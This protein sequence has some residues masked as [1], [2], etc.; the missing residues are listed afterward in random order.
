MGDKIQLARP[1]EPVEPWP[2]ALAFLV[3]FMAVY[4]VGWAWL[5]WLS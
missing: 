4:V 2:P 1:D 3:A 5:E